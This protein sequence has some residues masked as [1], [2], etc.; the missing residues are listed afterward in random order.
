MHQV[1]STI[2]DFLA[3]IGGHVAPEA[4]IE[5][6]R[7]H[8]APADPR[9]SSAE[10]YEIPANP[11]RRLSLQLF[12]TGLSRTYLI[13]QLSDG[14][15]IRPV[16]YATVACAILKRDDRQLAPFL[17]PL[18]A[19]LVLV[20]LSNLDEGDV[21]E[22]YNG[23]IEIIDTKPTSS[24]YMDRRLAAITHAALVKREMQEEGLLA[25]SD[26]REPGILIGIDGPLSNIHGAA[27]MPGV[28]GIVPAEPEVL[29]PGNAVLGCPFM[30][31]SALDSTKSPPAFYLRLRDPAGRN[32]DFGLMRVELGLTADGGKPDETWASDVASILFKERLPVDTH[33]RGWDKSIF[34]LQHAGRYIDTLIPPPRVV[35]TYFGR[36]TS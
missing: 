22:R 11:S 16:H 9:A 25:C 10:F 24:S 1:L 3:E 18:K 4:T 5:E 27:G 6:D 34:A 32:P 8:V 26:H 23:E 30:A 28:I 17:R 29:G 21:I 36:S 35:T 19:D 15:D 20:D 2:R 31:R 7:Y 13:G 14:P 12:Q 33:S